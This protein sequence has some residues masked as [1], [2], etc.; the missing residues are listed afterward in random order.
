MAGEEWVLTSVAVVVTVEVDTTVLTGQQLETGV[1]VFDVILVS[2]EE[3]VRAGQSVIVDAQ[4]VT[5]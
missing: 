1:G 2:T 5:V 3:L 4:E